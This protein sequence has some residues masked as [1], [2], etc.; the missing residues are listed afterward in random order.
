VPCG[1]A[2]D[3]AFLSNSSPK[4][5]SGV[6]CIFP[7]LKNYTSVKLNAADTE[8]ENFINKINIEGHIGLQ[9]AEFSE[10]YNEEQLY[11][12]E[13]CNKSFSFNN[14]L[15]RH[16]STCSREQTSAVKCVLNR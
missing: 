11:S 5:N 7:A 10:A 2:K 9:N 15:Q 8:R 14:S 6:E 3:A 13:K 1:I 4:N 12:C 16:P